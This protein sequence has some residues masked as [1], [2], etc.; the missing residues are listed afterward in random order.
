MLFGLCGCLH[1]HLH[2]PHIDICSVGCGAASD[3]PQQ[4]TMICLV[5]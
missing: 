5:L 2:V 1:S 4:L 3:C